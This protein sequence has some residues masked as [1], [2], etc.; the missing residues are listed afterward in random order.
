MSS[1]FKFKSSNLISSGTRYNNDKVKDRYYSIGTGLI[2]E[3]ELND[4]ELKLGFAL[5]DIL[6]NYET[7]FPATDNNK[8]NKNVI[9]LSIREM[10]N[11][12]T[13]EIRASIKK[14]KKIYSSLIDVKEE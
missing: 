8:F 11:M 5:I 2:E 1:N 14:F 12:S 13:K 7:I 4:N 6:D 9:L 10:T 3:D